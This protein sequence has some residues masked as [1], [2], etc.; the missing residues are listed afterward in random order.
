MLI[1]ELI[2]AD[3]FYNSQFNLFHLG[4][5]LLPHAWPMLFNHAQKKTNIKGFSLQHFLQC[6]WIVSQLENWAKGIFAHRNKQMETLL[7][8]TYCWITVCEWIFNRIVII[9]TSL[10]VIRLFQ[11]FVIYAFFVCVFFKENWHFI[12]KYININ[13]SCTLTDQEGPVPEY[14]LPF[15]EEVGQHP[16]L[17]DMQECVVAQ[18]ARPAI[19]DC[20]RKNPVSE[21]K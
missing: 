2:G 21:R 20:W 15:E 11:F 7:F 3:W 19:R 5:I 16:T 14:H 8:V 6:F 18:K 12:P 10:G 17:D 4:S 13:G 1:V 9:F